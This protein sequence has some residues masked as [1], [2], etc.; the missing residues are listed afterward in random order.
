M[1]HSHRFTLLLVVSALLAPFAFAQGD[2]LN[3]CCSTPD[4]AALASAIGGPDAV[5]TSFAKGP[6]DPH[7]VEAK[8]S[9]VKILAGADFLVVTGLELE[10]GWVPRLQ[11]NARNAKVMVGAP[12]YVEAA[13]AVTPLGAPSGTVDRS[14]GDVH[15]GGNPHFLADP[16]QGLKVAA[17]LCEKFTA[18]RPEKKDAFAARYAEFKKSIGAALVGDALAAKYDFLKLALLAEQGKLTGFLEKQ[19]D[20]AALGG[21]LG[22]TADAFGQKVVSDHDLWPYFARRFGIVVTGFLEPKPGVLPTTKH[23]GG[24]IERMKK[25]GV[26]VILSSPYFDPRHAEFVA[27]ATGARVAALAHQVGGRKGADDYLK[28]VSLNVDALARAL[29]GE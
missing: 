21:W 20:R 5:V 3:V 4:L 26:K 29:H 17:L 6:E 2:P 19:G 23:L 13:G 27:K 10:I 9:F 24:L 25:D 12:G 8:P 16:L 15:A 18:A 7:F 11:Q 1:M 14:M 22:K 28:F